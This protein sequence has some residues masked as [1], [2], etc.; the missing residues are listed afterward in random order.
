MLR[1]SGN[2]V[3][4]LMDRWQTASP[5]DFGALALTICVGVWFFSRYYSD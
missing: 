3:D 1:H 4:F 5:T 2:L